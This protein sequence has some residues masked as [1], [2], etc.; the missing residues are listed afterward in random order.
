[1]IFEK[2]SLKEFKL[3]E[4][5]TLSLEQYCPERMIKAGIKKASKIPS[6][7]LTNVKEKVDLPL[8][9]IFNSKDPKTLIIIK[10]TL[11]NLKT[12]DRM[13]NALKRSNLLIASN[14]HQT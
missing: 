1:M 2:D 9:S 13:E 3:G 4:L 5:E 14:M 8:T 11:E 7:A 10:Q 6:Y 12:S